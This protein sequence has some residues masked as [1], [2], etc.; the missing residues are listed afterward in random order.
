LARHRELRAVW[1]VAACDD[2]AR[3][4]PGGTAKWFLS[5]SG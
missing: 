2:R 1:H 3:D 5:V 4:G